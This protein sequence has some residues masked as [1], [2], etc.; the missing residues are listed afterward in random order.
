MPTVTDSPRTR[1]HR[2]P[3]PLTALVP[4]LAVW[5]LGTAAVVL[6]VPVVVSAPL[7][8]ATPVVT[9]ACAGLGAVVVRA[10]LRR[11]PQPLDDDDAGLRLGAGIAVIGQLLDVVLVVVNAGT[12]PRTDAAGTTV[13]LLLLLAGYAAFAV[14]GHLSW[15]ARAAAPAPSDR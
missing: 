14:G 10:L 5:A 1:A 6:A 4:G 12:Y 8:L 11:R 3:W 15:S 9:L 13:V 7:W 2:R